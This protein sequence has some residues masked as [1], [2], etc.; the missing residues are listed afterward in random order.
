MTTWLA[1]VRVII[2]KDTCDEREIY[3]DNVLVTA[4]SQEDAEAKIHY[5]IGARFSEPYIDVEF[6][7]HVT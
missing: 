6:K 1:R 2:D 4:E 7:E 5:Q 3:D